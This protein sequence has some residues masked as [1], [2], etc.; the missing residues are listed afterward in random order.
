MGNM[1]LLGVLVDPEILELSMAERTALSIL[2]TSIITGHCSCGGTW[3]TVED[4][5][6]NVFPTILHQSHCP[7]TSMSGRN[8]V[9]KVMKHIVH[10]TLAEGDV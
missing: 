3:E 8:A 2:S 10:S 5:M 7:G 4:D 1:V 9:K 6:G